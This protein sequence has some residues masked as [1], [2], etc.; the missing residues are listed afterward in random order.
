MIKT[1]ALVQAYVLFTV[2]AGVSVHPTQCQVETGGSVEVGCTTTSKEKWPIWLN[3]SF[4][5]QFA[6]HMCS[7]NGR[8]LQGLETKF[9]VTKLNDYNYQLT[10]L[11]VQPRDQG[12]YICKQSAFDDYTA[13][14][15]MTV[16]GTAIIICLSVVISSISCPPE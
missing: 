14:M 15:T 10:I 12:E 2:H 1:Y 6:R 9:R 3:Q 8:V 4:T 5:E 16:I 11:D 13:N 7:P